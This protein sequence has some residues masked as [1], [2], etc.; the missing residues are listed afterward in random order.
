MSDIVKSIRKLIEEI[1]S[2]Y[3]TSEDYI[4][5]A[6]TIGHHGQQLLSQIE[7]SE[8]AEHFSTKLKYLIRSA[9]VAAGSWAPPEAITEMS[10][11][12]YDLAISLKNLRDLLESSDVTLKD[13]GEPN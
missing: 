3:A 5:A 2:G 7:T 12:S 13:A 10:S 8:P 6:H 9:K 4:E 11:A 1:N